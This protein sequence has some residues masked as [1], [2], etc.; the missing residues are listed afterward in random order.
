MS[1]V[2]HTELRSLLAAGAL[3]PF[4]ESRI[5]GASVDVTLGDV[6]WREVMLPSDDACVDLA[7]KDVPRMLDYKMDADGFLLRPGDFI[8]A[9][10]A[11][12][13]DLPD[14]TAIEFKLKSS[15]ARAGLNHSLAGWGDP[16]WHGSVLTL[17]LSNLCRYHSLRLRPNMP[18]GQV[19]FWRGAQVPKHASYRSRGQYNGDTTAQPSKG[20]R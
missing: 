7:A 13:F 5:N 3:M 4:D 18:I 20:L 10:T 2:T 15:A 14:D 9:Q 1:L 17:E 19:V 12:L 11:E 8:L 16:G 6:I